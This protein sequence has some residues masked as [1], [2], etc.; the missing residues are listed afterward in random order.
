MK[1][2]RAAMFATCAFTHKAK[3]GTLLYGNW[4]AFTEAFRQQFYPLHEVTDAMNQLESRQYHQRKCSVDDYIDRF[5]ELVEKAG[6]TDG[7]SIVMKF[8]QGLDPTIQSHIALMLDGRLKDDDAPA[9]YKAARTVALTC[10][11]NEAFQLP[12]ATAMSPLPF[13]SVHRTGEPQTKFIAPL[14]TRPAAIPAHITPAASSGAAPM[15]VDATK[16]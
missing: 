12:K 3:N 7:R 15:D 11:A 5:E 10:A 6:Y 2:G 16:R 14:A 8:C 1:T 9:W 4:K 13:M